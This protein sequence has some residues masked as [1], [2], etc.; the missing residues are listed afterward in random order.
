MVNSF[1]DENRVFLAGRL[2]EDTSLKYTKT[3]VPVLRFTLA[4]NS[5]IK[6]KKETL[7]IPVVVYGE[8]ALEISSFVKRGTPVRVE[9]RLVNR[10]VK[11]GEEEHKFIEVVANKVEIYTKQKEE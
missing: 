4:V 8:L 1:K 11:I 7:F 3:K 5:Y 6:E 10:V 9:G 2:T